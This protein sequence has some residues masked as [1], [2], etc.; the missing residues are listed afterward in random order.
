MW[1]YWWISNFWTH[2]RNT[3]LEHS[4][5]IALR[6]M[7]QDLTDDK[8]TLF[9]VM[10]WC[11]QAPSH[12]LSQC[13]PHSTMQYGVTRPLWVNPFWPSDTIWQCRSRSTLAQV[14]ACCLMVPSHYLNRFC[15]FISEVQRHSSEGNFTRPLHSLMTAIVPF[16][17]DISPS[18][19]HLEH[20]ILAHEL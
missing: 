10:A 11:P 17:N 14:M 16:H 5:E 2:I 9:A 6:W 7:L 19:E 15:L 20:R 12:Y 3:Y 4:Y 18:G 1:L 8:W 13:R